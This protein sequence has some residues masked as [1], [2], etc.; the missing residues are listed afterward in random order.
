M[1]VPPD[2]RPTLWRSCRVLAN[3][4]RLEIF[5]FL[6]RNPDQTVSSVA[7]N[8]GLTEPVASEYL[9]LLESRGFLES[10]RVGRYVKYRVA[11]TDRI[12][13]NVGLVRVLR[14]IFERNRKSGRA[15]F[16]LVTGFTHP[17]RIDIVRALRVGSMSVNQ[18]RSFTEISIPALRR[19]L[20]KL[21]RRGF[22]K[23]RQ[24]VYSVARRFGPLQRELVRLAQIDVSDLGE[25]SRSV[26]SVGLGDGPHFT[27][28][29]HAAGER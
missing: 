26:A 8:E 29:E 11:S 12:H 4:R 27:K 6:L 7:R 2:V 25:S 23:H 28:C 20:M 14:L 3:H 24:G 5:D 9:R 1:Q 17:R 18:L 19:H 13:F 10:R 16:R 22:I 15:I 21:E